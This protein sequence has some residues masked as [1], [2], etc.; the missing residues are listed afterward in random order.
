MKI[1][2]NYQYRGDLS[3][4]EPDR[5]DIRL[6]ICGNTKCVTNL[7]RIQQVI[8]LLWGKFHKF[9]GTLDIAKWATKYFSESLTEIE[10]QYKIYSIGS[11][12]AFIPNKTKICY[13]SGFTQFLVTL[14]PDLNTSL[15]LLLMTTLSRSL[16]PLPSLD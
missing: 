2:G 11:K 8:Y 4:V 16:T 10:F 7:P 13:R 14:S 3:A 9:Y 1:P 6:R 15:C 12:L 5:N